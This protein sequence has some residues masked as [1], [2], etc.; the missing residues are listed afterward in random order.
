V[1]VTLY[2]LTNSTGA[3][4]KLAALTIENSV[5]PGQISCGDTTDLSVQLQDRLDN[6][7][8]LEA[9]PKGYLSKLTRGLELQFIRR[10]RRTQAYNYSAKN[11]R[12]GDPL[13]LQYNG[14]VIAG[15]DICGD[16]LLRLSYLDTPAAEGEVKDEAERDIEIEDIEEADLKVQILPGMC[17]SIGAAWRSST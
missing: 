5:H 16:A 11:W 3:P 2:F 8:D 14:L 10:G 1:A 13:T 9:L 12:V 15:E 7:I 17:S 4:Y 6:P